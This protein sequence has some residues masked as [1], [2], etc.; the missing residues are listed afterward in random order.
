MGRSPLCF[1]EKNLVS[2][3]NKAF[4]TLRRCFAGDWNE[5]MY[6][7]GPMSSKFLKRSLPSFWSFTLLGRRF[8]IF[9]VQAFQA[10][11]TKPFRHLERIPLVFLDEYFHISGMK[12]PKA[13]QAF[14]VKLFK[15]PRRNLPSFSDKIF[16]ARPCILL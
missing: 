7:S 6:T 4:Q 9:L 8:S 11:V 3:W 2:F 15:A 10:S 13:F 12:S 16:W 5:N 1:W 14:E